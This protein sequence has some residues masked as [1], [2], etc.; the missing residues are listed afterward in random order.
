MKLI[1]FKQ[2]NLEDL[3][4]TQ[5]QITSELSTIQMQTD[6]ESVTATSFNTKLFKTVFTNTFT[7]FN[8]ES[9]INNEHLIIIS[10]TIMILLGFM[11]LFFCI[12]NIKMK[13][14]EN[15]SINLLRKVNDTLKLSIVKM[16]EASTVMNS[17]T[18]RTLTLTTTK[19]LTSIL[20]EHDEFPPLL[21]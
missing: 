6:I 15:R 18:H 4:T 8:S 2:T 17:S 19:L 10:L 14:R 13:K 9:I 3:T 16:N 12:I 5:Q 21:V 11:I 1:L 20:R 7:T